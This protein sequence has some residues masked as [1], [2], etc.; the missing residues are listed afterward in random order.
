MRIY[1]VPVTFEV[2]LTEKELS[3]SEN[4][5]KDKLVTLIEMDGAEQ[6]MEL[7]IA[8]EPTELNSQ[9]NRDFIMA[10]HDAY[11]TQLMA[12][13]NGLTDDPDMTAEQAQ[14]ILRE[15]F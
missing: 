15:V 7:G 11:K 9:E 1:K 8:D 2:F 4:P 12:I 3:A 13:A 10:S 5:A 14:T 6:V